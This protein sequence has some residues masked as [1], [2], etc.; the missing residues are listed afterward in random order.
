[1][2]YPNA[3]VP[4]GCSRPARAAN[5]SSNGAG[6]GSA[7]ARRIVEVLASPMSGAAIRVNFARMSA[8]CRFPSRADEMSA[9]PE[10]C[11]PPF[12]VSRTRACCLA[13]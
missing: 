2:P 7:N 13:G 6:A 5:T 8:G 4:P 1:M 11:L 12:S 9:A 3:V 10:S